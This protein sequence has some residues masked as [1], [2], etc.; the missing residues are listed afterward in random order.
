MKKFFAFF[1]VAALLA[2]CDS[3]GETN[4]ETADNTETEAATEQVVMNY[5]GDT[6]SA[7]GAVSAAEA[8]EIV[9]RDG[10]FEGKVAT[11]IQGTCKKKG[12]WMK[13][14]VTEEEEMR[15]TF[16]DYGFFVP[17]EG[18]EGKEVIMQGM[19]Y[20]DTTTVEMLRHYAEDAGQS[21]EEI[22]AITEPEYALAFEA[23]GVIIKE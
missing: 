7:D 13:V 12:C 3:T 11:K 2:S 8:A 9:K 18:A 1:A 22:E 14:D 10:G 5:Y 15:V 21:P 20:L 23:T 17:K 4:N 6:I 16:K 19:A